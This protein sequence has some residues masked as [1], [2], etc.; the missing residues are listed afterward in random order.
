MDGQVMVSSAGRLSCKKIIHA[1]GP[2]WR[3]GY[4][5]EERTLYGCIDNC[6]EESKKQKF[7]SIAIPPVST[8]IFGYPLDKAVKTIVDVVFHRD[9]DGDYLP[10][11]IMFVDNKEN[12]LKLFEKELRGLYSNPSSSGTGSQPQSSR[13]PGEYTFMLVH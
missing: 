4:S 6:F 12:S 11:R 7:Q 1:V 8:G 2:R 9:R 10:R 13:Q 5:Q 3:N